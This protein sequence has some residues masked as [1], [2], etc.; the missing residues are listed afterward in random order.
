MVPSSSNFLEVQ[1]DK[2]V[3][4]YLNTSPINKKS[5]SKL[6]NIDGDSLIDLNL[7][8]RNPILFL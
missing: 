3:I 7:K 1:L 4:D 6:T 5:F 8:A 2:N